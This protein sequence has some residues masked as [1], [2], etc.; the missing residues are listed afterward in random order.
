MGCIR[1]QSGYIALLAVLI[2]GAASLAIASALLLTATDSQRSTLVAQQAAQARSLA[3]ACGEE[4]LQKL[5]ETPSY[6]G[7]T[8]VGA[9]GCSFT[10]TNTGGNNRLVQASATVGTVIRRVSISATI[11]ATNITVSSWQDVES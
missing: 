9:I 6:T 2:V 10:V 1:S 8:N 3:T 5:Y 11:G 4:G 7:T